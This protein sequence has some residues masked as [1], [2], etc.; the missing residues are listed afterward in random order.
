MSAKLAIWRRALEKFSCTNP[1]FNSPEEMVQA[2][3]AY[4]EWAA[5]N[6][7]QEE[8]LFHYQ[9]SVTTAQ[10]NVMRAFTLR[11]LCIFCGITRSTWDRYR[12]LEPYAELCSFVEDIIYTQKFEGA[13]ANLLNATIIAR[14]LGLAEKTDL[15]SKDGTMSPPPAA[16]DFTKM[17]TSALAELFLLKDTAHAA[18]DE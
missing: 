8:K 12:S 3:T 11:G 2:T 7:L 13:A 5:S 9:G 10:G 18:P 17:S 4:F 14:D 6:P 1:A 15:S 16:L